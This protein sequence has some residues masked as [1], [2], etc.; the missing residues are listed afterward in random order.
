MQRLLETILSHLRELGP[1][2]P[3]LSHLLEGGLGVQTMLFHLREWGG[4]LGPSA[5]S[6]TYCGTLDT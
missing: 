1:W 4:G 3:V 5:F 6:N 2:G